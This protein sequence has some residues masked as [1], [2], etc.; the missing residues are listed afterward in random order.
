MEKLIFESHSSL[1]FVSVAAVALMTPRCAEIG[2]H[3]HLLDSL[4]YFTMA[5]SSDQKHQQTE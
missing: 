1:W 3:S 5:S 2:F 4:F